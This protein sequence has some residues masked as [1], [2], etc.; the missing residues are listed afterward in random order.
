MKWLL[1]SLLGTYL[2]VVWAFVAVMHA[3]HRM[4]NGAL[5]VFWRVH[6]LPLAV[7][8]IA[9]DAIFNATFGWLMFLERPHEL[10]FSGRVQRHCRLGYGWRK[11][12]AVFWANQLN[13]MDPGH[14]RA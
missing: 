6:L 11:R 10:L 9:L 14:I 8:G 12:L 4:E 7:I 5:T 1:I 2:G 13:Q 3:K